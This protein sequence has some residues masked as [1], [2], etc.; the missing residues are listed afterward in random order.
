MTGG[1]LTIIGGESDETLGDTLNIIGPATVNM[2]GAESGTVTWL[3]GA[4]LSFSEIENLSYTAC[5]TDGS[6]IA[7]QRGDIRAHDL[8]P[9]DMVLTR[10]N[11]Y[12]PI[13]WKGS[14]HFTAAQLLKDPALRPVRI[15]SG[16]LDGQAPHRPLLVSPQHRLLF[17]GPQAE[18]LF[19]EPEVLVP[20]IHLT[21]RPG[22]RQVMPPKGVTYVH[23]MF[24]R[25][26]IVLSD[27]AW[28]E[29]FQPGDLSLAGLGDS[30]RNELFALFPE[31]ATQEGRTAYAPARMA[32]RRHQSRLLLTDKK[33]A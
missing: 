28:S 5:F 9:G 30:Q 20:A 2:T 21:G 33:V 27:G 3:D 12:Q 14:V 1:A 4:V 29:S 32:L 17:G 13:V 11:G 23:F 15:A 19:A 22:V 26:E 31:L 24:E 7:T 6:R 8:V 25:H 10:D 16:A 18:L